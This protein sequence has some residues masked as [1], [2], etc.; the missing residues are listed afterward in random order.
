MSELAMAV[1]RLAPKRPKDVEEEKDN[2]FEQPGKGKPFGIPY[3]NADSVDEP[4]GK[5]HTIKYKPDINADTVIHHIIGFLVRRMISKPYIRKSSDGTKQKTSTNWHLQKPGVYEGAVNGVGGEYV[6]GSSEKKIDYEKRVN[7]AVKSYFDGLAKLEQLERLE[8]VEERKLSLKWIL[9]NLGYMPIEGVIDWKDT[10]DTLEPE[11]AKICVREIL[12][13][14]GTHPF[15]RIPYYGIIDGLNKAIDAV[16]THSLTDAIHSFM[17]DD[18]IRKVL[19]PNELLARIIELCEPQ[20]VRREDGEVAYNDNANVTGEIYEI[21]KE[22]HDYHLRFG[23]Y[24]I[25]T[26]SCSRGI[27]CRPEKDY[28]IAGLFKCVIDIKLPDDM[29]ESELQSQSVVPLSD[30]MEEGELQGQS[31]M[32]SDNDEDPVGRD[33]SNRDSIIKI[34]GDINS[35]HK[36]LHESKNWMLSPRTEGDSDDGPKVFQVMPELLR[37]FILIENLKNITKWLKKVQITGSGEEVVIP[38]IDS[39]LLYVDYDEPAPGEEGSSRDQAEPAPGLVPDLVFNLNTFLKEP[40]PGGSVAISDI[41]NII[42]ILCANKELLDDDSVKS[43]LITIVDLI[44]QDNINGLITA[45]ND[46]ISLK[47]PY[48][49]GINRG[50]SEKFKN[51]L[52]HSALLIIFDK[53]VHLV[54]MEYSKEVGIVLDSEGNPVLDDKDNP[55]PIKQL[56]LA[57]NHVLMSLPQLNRVKFLGDMSL[58][59]AKHMIGTINGFLVNAEEITVQAVNGELVVRA[60]IKPGYSTYS[61]PPGPGQCNCALFVAECL[62]GAYEEK[63]M[64]DPIDISFPWPSTLG[65]MDIGDIEA[66]YKQLSH[67]HAPPPSVADAD[68]EYKETVLRVAD[69]TV[70][71]DDSGFDEDPSFVSEDWGERE[72]VRAEAEE[73]E[74]GAKKMIKKRK[75]YKTFGVSKKKSRRRNRRKC[76]KRKTKKKPRVLPVRFTTKFSRKLR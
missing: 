26:D 24:R 30:Y 67:S 65:E 23:A 74:G 17:S 54:E 43:I 35:Q 28:R 41:G 25:L 68:K 45:L 57:F 13:V 12:T 64:P 52:S 29:E 11:I 39:E 62:R 7:K 21:L 4:D 60:Y 53:I 18:N 27:L 44:N 76:G 34:L 48:V 9:Q 59:S 69:G 55:I 49:A 2:E 56:V 38:D 6:F 66:T 46:F 33:S 10:I 20:K 5:D 58:G 51:R 36:A 31:G 22:A 15:E 40:D 47:Q 3:D 50:L 63:G 14:Y 73:E 37:R 16:L 71:D 61:K 70:V 19:I 42:G 8:E 32:P 1:D 72:T 75:T